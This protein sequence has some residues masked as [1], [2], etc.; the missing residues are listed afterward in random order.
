MKIEGVTIVDFK[1]VVSN[2][3]SKERTVINTGVFSCP[4][5]VL[6][7]KTFRQLVVTKSKGND[8]LGNHIWG[9]PKNEIRLIDCTVKFLDL[10]ALIKFYNHPEKFK[11]IKV[12]D[13]ML[14]VCED[15]SVVVNGNQRKI[16]RSKTG[17]LQISLGANLYSVA[18]LVAFAWL[19]KC[20]KS[21]YV[22]EFHDGNPENMHY[23]NL[24]Y[25]RWKVGCPRKLTA[26]DMNDIRRAIDRGEKM[27]DLASK[28]G[29]NRFTITRALKRKA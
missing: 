11:T 27:C 17:R 14:W 6:H 12:E 16:F 21:N 29:V 1:E 26:K 28:Y 7:G 24:Y 4:G 10:P 25:T 22:V 23:T 19:L 9:E 13:C 2:T 3:L 20:E 15:G 18:R 5:M 8:E